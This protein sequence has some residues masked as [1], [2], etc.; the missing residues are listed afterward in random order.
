MSSSAGT[1]I[2]DIMIALLAPHRFRT[3]LVYQGERLDFGRT[4]RHVLDM[5]GDDEYGCAL[6]VY[7]LSLMMELA[8]DRTD[9]EVSK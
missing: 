1:T 7:D 4:I 5:L 9:R 8:F 3:C 6:G 2:D